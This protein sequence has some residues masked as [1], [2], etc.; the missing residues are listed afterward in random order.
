MPDIRISFYAEREG[1]KYENGNIPANAVYVVSISGNQKDEKALIKPLGKVEYKY[2]SKRKKGVN[3][4][5]Y[6]NL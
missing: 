6:K 4:I 2:V 5:I 1:V 3:V